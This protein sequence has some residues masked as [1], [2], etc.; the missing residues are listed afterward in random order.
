[1]ERN[2]EMWGHGKINMYVLVYYTYDNND[3]LLC[4]FVKVFY[5]A[6]EAQNYA[7]DGVKNKVVGDKSKGYVYQ[8]PRVFANEYDSEVS[9]YDNSDKIVSELSPMLEIRTNG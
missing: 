6:T 1:M 3:R 8:I 2:F 5:N 9:I 4:E 7:I